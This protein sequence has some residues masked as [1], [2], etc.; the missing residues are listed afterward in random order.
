MTTRVNYLQEAGETAPWLRCLLH[1][2]EDLRSIPQNP[3][4]TAGHSETHL[5]PSTEGTER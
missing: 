5:Y 1:R 2:L 3:H 4:V